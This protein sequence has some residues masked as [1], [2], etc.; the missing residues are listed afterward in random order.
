MDEKTDSLHDM[1]K[2]QIVASC[3]DLGL[4]SK[5]EY[6]GLDWRADAFV[7]ND[8]YKY[9]F[10]VQITNQ[11]LKK[12][13]ERQSKYI[14]DGVTGCW[15]FLRSPKKLQNE[16]PDLPLFELIQEDS[17]FLVSL[18]GRKILPLNI[19]LKDF[20]Q[21]KI[22]FCT[23]V[24]S[25]TTQNIEVAFYNMNC[26]KCG[27]VNQLYFIDSDF[28]SACNAKIY[29]EETM[30]SY[31][32]KEYIPEIKNYIIKYALLNKD[33]IPNLATIKERF[34]KTMDDSYMSF[35]CSHCDSI[36]GDWYIHEAVSEVQYGYGILHRIKCDLELNLEL[37]DEIPHW[38]HP[39]DHDFCK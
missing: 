18:S 3:K 22:K 31:D 32:K 7:L 23:T 16:R 35:G 4:F 28:K 38:C 30:W 13:L 19:F 15:L 37:E 12:T 2:H 9:A 5:T 11:T 10:E 27:A 6:K 20:L 26:W 36:F 21:N 33:T 34:S 24:K 25:T 14:R 29:Y 8:V 17:K 39:G 1:V